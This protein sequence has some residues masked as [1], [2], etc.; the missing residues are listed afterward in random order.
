MELLLCLLVLAFLAKTPS[1]VENGIL[2]QKAQGLL[3]DH[4]VG[5][6]FYFLLLADWSL[7]GGH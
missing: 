7:S 5:T 3:V 6:Q 1:P 2:E 4:F